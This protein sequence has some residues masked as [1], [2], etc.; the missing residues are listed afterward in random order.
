MHRGL[1][2]AAKNQEVGASGD[3]FLEK[4]H[5]IGSTLRDQ[6]DWARYLEPCFTS[7][8]FW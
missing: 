6:S 1:Q 5:K 2:A 7:I 8:D 3:Q 4:S